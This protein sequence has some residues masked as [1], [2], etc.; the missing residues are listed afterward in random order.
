MPRLAE[1]WCNSVAGE[2]MEED[3]VTKEDEVTV[4]EEEITKEE[5]KSQEV[6]PE[7]GSVP[8]FRYVV[9]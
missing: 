2:E 5:V 4:E 9:M 8:Y 1:D 3:E 7:H 6:Q